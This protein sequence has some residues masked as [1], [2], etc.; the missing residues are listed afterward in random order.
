MLRQIW[1]SRYSSVSICK[2]QSSWNNRHV[3]SK[4]VQSS[5]ILSV[6]TWDSLNVCSFQDAVQETDDVDQDIKDEKLSPDI[7]DDED[8]EMKL[9]VK[10]ASKVSASSHALLEASGILHTIVLDFIIIYFYSLS[11]ASH[12]WAY[13]V[14]FDRRKKLLY[15]SWQSD[16]EAWSRTLGSHGNSQSI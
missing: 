12:E 13:K 14:F 5:L 4:V 7:E 3:W 8:E 11:D 2:S 15:A 1:D 6:K 16:E 9:P 10:I